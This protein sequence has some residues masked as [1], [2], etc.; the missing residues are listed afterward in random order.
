MLAARGLRKVYAAGPRAVEA[1]AGVSLDVG[2]GEFVAIRGRSGSGKSTLLALLAGLCRPT[3]GSVRLDGTDV[4]SLG[5]EELAALRGRRVGFLFQFAGLLPALRAIDNVALPALV[6]GTADPESAYRRA[7]ELLG[8][9]GLAGRQEAYPAELSG[10]EQRRVALAR[11]LIHDPPLL[12]ADEPTSDLDEETEAEVLRLLVD[13]HRETGKALV[14]VTHDAEVARLADRV[15]HVSGGRVIR[16]EA[17]PGEAPPG[18]G[19][20][21]QEPVP[22]EAPPAPAPLGGGLGRFLV[23]AAC[24]LGILVLLVAGFNHGLARYQGA[25]LAERRSARERLEESALRQ[26][27]ADVEDVAYGP[28]RSYE[29]TLYLDNLAPEE[30]L[31]VLAPAVRAFVQVDRGWEEVPLEPAGGL[32]GQVVALA[33]RRRFRYRFTPQVKRYEELLPGYMHVRFSSA[34]LVRGAGE[35]GAG[36]FERTDDYYVYL[37]PHGADDGAILR[38]L[39]FP[40]KPPV[41]IPMPPH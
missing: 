17:G 24:W 2:A 11:A 37:K 4:W 16:E 19:A 9:V 20:G 3:A 30:E 25:R 40:G 14:V 22:A 29:L 41:W 23:D 18:P 31:H 28:G 13:V 10:G 35:P 8:R 34:M 32:S 15:L 1:V 26:L 7:A 38:K 33:G 36:L 5:P 6:A 12:L 39:R 21:R 27:R